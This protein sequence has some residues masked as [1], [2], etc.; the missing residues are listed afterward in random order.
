MAGIFISV[1]AFGMV[2]GFL[3]HMKSFII[4]FLGL[5]SMTLKSQTVQSSCQAADS[6]TNKFRSDADR[7]AVNRVVVKINSP[8]T[9]SVH[10]DPALRQSYLNALIA[11]YN[12]TVIPARD[13]VINKYHIHRWWEPLNQIFLNA[14]SNL[15]WMKNFRNNVYPVGNAFI[16]SL[17]ARHYL[18]K[19]F[20]NTLGDYYSYHQLTP[21]RTQIAIHSHFATCS[22]I[23]LPG[24]AYARRIFQR[25]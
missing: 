10:V 5:A 15:I 19:Q 2:F 16:D 21:R 12:A 8:Y 11:V 22:L 7:M 25:V 14:D 6:I 3:T 4:L 23:M 9:D 24:S 17:R 18:V 1:Y 13:S 20:Y